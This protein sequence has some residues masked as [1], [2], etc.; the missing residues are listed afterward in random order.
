MMRSL[1]IAALL[2]AVASATALAT[3]APQ[4]KLSESSNHQTVHVSRGTTLIVTLHSTY[5]SLQAPSGGVLRA[6]GPPRYAPA[7]M[8]VCVPG[9]GCGTVTESY[10]ATKDGVG[11]IN[12]SRT[13]CGVALRA[14]A[15]DVHRPRRNRSLTLE[16]GVPW[17]SRRSHTTS[18]AWCRASSRTGAPAR[19]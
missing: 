11:A 9:G 8:G 5:W 19:S 3:G 1:A 2:L 12:A 15:A 7:A 17:T 16:S 10:R 13:T 6:V 14:I 4:R 18:A